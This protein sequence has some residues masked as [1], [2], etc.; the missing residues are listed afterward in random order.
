[1][2]R[3]LS[4][5]AM[6]LLVAQWATAGD[7]VTK[8]AKRLPEQART[9]IKK[10]FQNPDVSYIKIDSEFLRGKK[11]EV[12]LT[13][14]TEIEFDSKGNWSEVDSKRNPVPETIIPDYIRDYVKENFKT[15]RITQIE[16]DRF[17]IEVELTNDLSLRFD[18]NGVLREIDN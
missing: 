5:V 16:K 6:F 9:F 8:D 1:M 12:V 11:Y 17:G 18:K 10:H 4:V 15:E 2:K 3:I 14:G 13:N 7:V